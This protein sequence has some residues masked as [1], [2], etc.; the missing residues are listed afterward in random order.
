VPR[1]PL[2]RTQALRAAV[3]A[4]L[5]QAHADGTEPLTVNQ[6]A[7]FVAGHEHPNR[8][9]Q[10]VYGYLRALVDEGLAVRY[11]G[12]GLHLYEAAGDLVE[13]VAELPPL[14]V[15]AEADRNAPPPASRRSIALPEVLRRAIQPRGSTSPAEDEQRLLGD[16][17][18]RLTTERRGRPPREPRTV[19]WTP[20]AA[21]LP[22]AT[23]ALAAAPSTG[24]VRVIHVRTS[25]GAQITDAGG[26]D[27][28]RYRIADHE[29][30]TCRRCLRTSWW[31]QAVRSR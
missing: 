11:D 27:R 14:E 20:P 4:C 13:P 8:T 16:I 21:W 25:C 29:A 2:A 5:V 12:N 22:A 28:L 1:T 23:R 15:I 31:A 17:R 30:V 26:L 10:Q 7:E 19:H 18:R 6:V 24:G 9:H 3:R